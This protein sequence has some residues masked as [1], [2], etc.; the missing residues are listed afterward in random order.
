MNKKRKF[1]SVE[2]SNKIRKLD[3]KEEFISI[4]NKNYNYSFKVSL[5]NLSHNRYN[6][7]LACDDTLFKFKD[8]S[9]YINANCIKYKHMSFIAT[10]AP[11]KRTMSTFMNMIWKSKSETVIT[12]TSTSETNTRKMDVY[13]PEKVG[14]RLM[15][16]KFILEF[17]QENK[18]PNYIIRYFNLF[19]S[20]QIHTFKQI[21]Y[22]EWPNADVP[23]NFNDLI[24]IYKII[25]FTTPPIVH[26]SASIGRTGTFIGICI[27]LNLIDIKSKDISVKDIVTSLRKQRY[28]MVQTFG[29]YKFIYRCMKYHLNIG[30]ENN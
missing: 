3:V 11:L 18:F 1:I 2:K 5:S 25:D 9:K 7:V 4:K 20:D 30:L 23:K 26:C 29:Q 12:L 24:D 19:K 14:S 16:D 17:K 10:Q 27:I 8:E 28:G 21:H 6:N 15:F 13:W 22:T